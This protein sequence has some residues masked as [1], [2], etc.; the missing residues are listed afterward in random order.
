MRVAAD[1]G[2]PTDDDTLAAVARLERVCFSRAD[3]WNGERESGRWRED[4]WWG[5]KGAGQK[6]RRRRRRPRAGATNATARTPP[7]L[8][9]PGDA[10]RAKASKRNALLLTTGASPADLTGYLF[11][12]RTGSSLHVLR[13]AVAPTARRTGVA[14]ALLTAA[15]SPTKRGGARPLALTLH[16]DPANTT[17]VSLYV[18]AGF[19]DDGGLLTDYYSPGRPAQRMIREREA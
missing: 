15:S 16:V 1:G 12:T 2:R 6:A 14:T 11:A 13:V 19:V 10:V 5:W 9:P 4:V 17:A 7:L 8:L 3:A 18:G